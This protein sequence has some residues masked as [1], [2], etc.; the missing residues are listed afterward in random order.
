MAH[1]PGGRA[2]FLVVSIVV[3]AVM[4][5]LLEGVRAIVLRAIVLLGP[6]P[7]PAARA[8]GIHD[9][10]YAMVMALALGLAAPI[11]RYLSRWTPRRRITPSG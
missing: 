7:V 5:W 8:I 10:H 3:F 1:I 6:L 11:L 4:G 2:G 9:V